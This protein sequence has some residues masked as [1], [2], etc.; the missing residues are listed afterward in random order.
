M[1]RDE[2][3]ALAERCRHGTVDEAGRLIE[4]AWSLSAEAS[5]EFRRFAVRH[6]SGFDNNAGRFSML[7]EA[8]AHH[9]AALMLVPDDM[10]D[11]ME[12]T[13]L[14]QAA[15]VI[16]N[17]NHGDDGSPFYGENACNCV[18]LAIVDASLRA[19]AALLSEKGEG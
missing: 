14:Y 10:R 8:R 3:L 7:L 13:T 6:L 19:R 4:E 16:I 15:R 9:D 11:E 2:M 12:T 17:M 5:A 18:P 1:T